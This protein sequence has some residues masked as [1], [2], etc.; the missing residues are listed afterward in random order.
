MG[1]AMGLS[2]AIDLLLKDSRKANNLILEAIVLGPERY[3]STV[4][5]RS[6]FP[7]ICIYQIQ[8]NETQ[9]LV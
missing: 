5:F 4:V 9:C 8:L 1:L 6:F 2:V 3:L 7:I